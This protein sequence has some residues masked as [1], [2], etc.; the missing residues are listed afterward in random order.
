MMDRRIKNLLALMTSAVKSGT[1]PKRQL[2]LPSPWESWTLISLVL[3]T[4]RQIWACRVVEERL[5]EKSG[6][7]LVPG[8][9]EWEYRF[10]DQGC[11]LTHRV[12]GGAIETETGAGFD[13]YYWL[14]DL[15]STHNHDL[16]TRKMLALHPSLLSLKV[17]L[18]LLYSAGTI[19]AGGNTPFHLFAVKKVL[20]R[21]A[22]IIRR[23]CELLEKDEI[24]DLADALDAAGETRQARLDF[25]LCLLDMK[26]KKQKP[27]K[28]RLPGMNIELLEGPSIGIEDLKRGALYVLSDMGAAEF[29]SRLKRALQERPFSEFTSTAMYM[30]DEAN[31][32]E[33]CDEVYR[34]LRVLSPAGPFPQPYFWVKCVHFLLRHRHRTGEMLQELPKAGQ[35]YL[36]QAALLELEFGSDPTPLFRR[37]FLEQNSTLMGRAEAAAVLA[38]LD[39]PWSRGILLSVLD[40][41]SDSETTSECRAALRECRDPAMHKAADD[42][43]RLHPS[44][45]EESLLNAGNLIRC[46]MEMLHDRVLALRTRAPKEQ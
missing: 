19:R 14:N 10:H 4:E 1:L 20:L 43:E 40:A 28:V 22:P 13:F 2:E 16:A 42:W 32:P 5:A 41:S 37:A 3:L 7:G 39:S 21:H 8:L 11:F 36:G 24:G 38:L 18:F 34:L 44:S 46:D 30:V 6:V 31:D 23:F 29:P 45:E 15:R 35:N 27:K 17:T 9:P 26:P 33:W 12:M 25:V